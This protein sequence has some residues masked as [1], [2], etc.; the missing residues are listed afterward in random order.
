MNYSFRLERVPRHR[1]YS[2][3]LARVYGYEGATVAFMEYNQSR[4]CWMGWN[5]ITGGNFIYRKSLRALRV[6]MERDV[7]STIRLIAQ[8]IQEE[9]S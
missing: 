7:E 8:T 6:V 3:K 4:K 1:A 2:L 9:A 5:Q